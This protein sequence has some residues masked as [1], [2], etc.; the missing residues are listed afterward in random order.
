MSERTNAAMR[1]LVKRRQSAGRCPR[2][3][4]PKKRAGYLCRGCADYHAEQ[5]RERRRRSAIEQG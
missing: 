1:R 3:D 5:A 4:E 2:C